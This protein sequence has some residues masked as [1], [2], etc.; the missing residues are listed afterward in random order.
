MELKNQSIARVDEL[1]SKIKIYELQNTKNGSE[2]IGSVY[3]AKFEE[4]FTIC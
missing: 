4:M 1:N 2:K 3:K